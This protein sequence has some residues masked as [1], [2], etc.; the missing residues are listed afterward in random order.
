MDRTDPDAAQPLIRRDNTK[1]GYWAE[2]ALDNPWS[3]GR[4]NSYNN[5]TTLFELR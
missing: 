2:A 5:K 4:R 1:S 3:R